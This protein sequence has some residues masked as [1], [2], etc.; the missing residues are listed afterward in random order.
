MCLRAVGGHRGQLWWDSGVCGVQWTR[1]F[2]IRG[3]TCMFV[4]GQIRDLV[5][6]DTARYLFE[7]E[8]FHSKR[9]HEGREGPKQRGRVLT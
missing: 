9:H 8:L 4:A 3:L 5:E 6:D 7:D 1:G 2:W